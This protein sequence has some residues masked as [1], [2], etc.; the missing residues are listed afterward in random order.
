MMGRKFVIASVAVFGIACLC[1]GCKTKEEIKVPVENENVPIKEVTQKVAP[2]VPK[3][4]EKKF[5]LYSTT[6]YDL[7]LFSIVEIS[8]LPPVVKNSVDKLLDESQGFYLLR[9][10]KDKI[11]VILQNPV[12]NS[13]TYPRHNLQVA[14]IDMDGN[15]KY[16]TAGYG[17]LEGEISISDE[18]QKDDDWEFDNSVEPARPVKHTAFDENGKI[19]FTEIWNYDEKE[20]IKYEMKDSNKKIISIFKETLE[21]DSNLR[22]EHIFYDNNGNTMMS[23][24]VNYDGANISRMTFYNSHDSIDSVSIISEYS[25]G[26]KIKELIYDENCELINVVTSSYHD[27]E[28][29]SIIIYDKNGTELA[30]IAS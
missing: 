19:K 11:F 30:K 20:P 9:K 7:P 13:D 28:R 26:V 6:P 5:D 2:I 18:T 12:T 8:K 22:K 25:N 24:S 29:E 3:K 27:G 21:S 1:T 14:E 16:H 23:L 15:V 10:D 17:G 4:I